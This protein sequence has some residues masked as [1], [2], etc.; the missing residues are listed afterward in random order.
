MGKRIIPRARGAGGPRYVAPSHRYLGKVEYF[1]VGSVSAKV[2]DIMHDAGRT[3][4]LI[5]VRSNAGREIFQIAPEGIAVGD[6]IDYGGSVSTGNVVELSVI[7]EGTKVFAIENHPGAGPKLCRGSG[8]FAT[9]LGKSGSKVAV[10]FPSGKV[11]ELDSRCRVTIGIPAASGRIEKPWAKAGTK[12]YAKMTRGKLLPRS[13]GVAMTPADHPY[14][15]KSK[16][17]R[18][19]RTVGRDAPPG[20][21]VGSIA[22]RRVGKRKGARNA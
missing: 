13:A 12:W 19:S 4:P 5:R 11:V 6:M 9:V 18:P 1:P 15:G 14:G 16:R 10:Q 8:V 20:Q 7:P 3:A 2:M 22:A 21:K 17:P